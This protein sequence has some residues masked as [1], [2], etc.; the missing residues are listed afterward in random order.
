MGIIVR[1]PPVGCCAIEL[2][3]SKKDLLAI[4]AL[5]DYEFLLDP[6]EPIFYV[7]RVF[8]L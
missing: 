4:R 6:L 2:V 7:H 5:G 8:G 1:L 3:H